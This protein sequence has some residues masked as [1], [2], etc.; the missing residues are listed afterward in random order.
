MGSIL[1]RQCCSRI[2]SPSRS[3]L[4]NWCA[5][6]VGMTKQREMMGLL[7]QFSAMHMAAMLDYECLH[8]CW[9]Y[10]HIRVCVCVCMCV[11]VCVCV[12]MCVYVCVCVCMCVYVCVC[13]YVLCM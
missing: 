1:S 11:Y 5:G 13:I 12:C 4:I 2:Q 8:Y 7:Y 10:A 6:M 3:T 9:V